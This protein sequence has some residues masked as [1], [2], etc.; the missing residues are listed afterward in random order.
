MDLVIGLLWCMAFSVI[1][2][3]LGALNY[4]LGR[5]HSN[6]ELSD[7]K[8]QLDTTNQQ[9]N[10]TKRKHTRNANKKQR[11]LA[12]ATAISDHSNSNNE[13]ETESVL[14]EIKNEEEEETLIDEQFEDP[15]KIE[16]VSHVED[17]QKPIG[18]VKQRNKNKSNSTNSKS[19]ISSKEES[20]FPLKPQA[21][22]A[23]VKQSLLPPI[24]KINNQSTQVLQDN[25]SKSNGH[26]S[27]CNIYSYAEHN[28]VPPRFQQQR[29]EKEE[30]NGQKFRKRRSNE[31]KTKSFNSSAS[32]VR[33]NDFLP[34]ISK[35][36][37]N[38]NNN[39]LE[40]PLQSSN[41]NGYSSESDML[42]GK[43]LF[44]QN[45]LIILIYFL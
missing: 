18:P 26:V 11:Q 35:Q 9:R 23:P 13:Q 30:A 38:N 31:K 33:Q 17:E 8:S 45:L 24:S 12:A 2:L 6:I 32:P 29:R 36:Q 1:V 42:T 15:M 27:S 16:E 41:Q 28:S 39:Q 3:F 21:S 37:L 43:I 4:F 14:S 34:L 22:V 19:T 44:S 10:S 40:L 5:S 20:I 25:H 7:K